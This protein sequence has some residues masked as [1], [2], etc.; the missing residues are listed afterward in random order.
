[1]LTP[2]QFA[3]NRPIDGI[4]LDGL[5]YTQYSSFKLVAYKRQTYFGL[6]TS[7]DVIKTASTPKIF[8]NN[9]PVHYSSEGK[10]DYGTGSVFKT[11]FEDQP[12]PPDD[13]DNPYLPTT[14]TGNKIGAVLDGITKV[15]LPA[16][17]WAINKEEIDAN[18]K[19]KSDAKA[20]NL[21]NAL[22]NKSINHYNLKISEQV[23]T[24]LI[25]YVNDGS[26][27]SAGVNLK[28]KSLDQIKAI[29]AYDGAI[30]KLGKL[31]YAHKD[32]FRHDT[33]QDKDYIK[34][35]GEK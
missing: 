28:G 1:M 2:Y 26:L 17:N 21:A 27:P 22:V 13:D 16:I 10:T 34:V 5:E 35:Y 29:K 6:L 33:K 7:V 32:D 8:D 23:K 14:E 30:E 15:I 19:L 25:N 20:L 12:D 31:I 9:L 3:S 24:D 4:D 11:E 18:K